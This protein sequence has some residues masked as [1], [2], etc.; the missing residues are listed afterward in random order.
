MHSLIYYADLFV[1]DSLTMFTESALLGTP[2]ISISS[3]GYL[4]GNF[5]E[6]CQKYELGFRFRSVSEALGKIKELLQKSDIKEEWKKKRNRLLAEKRDVTQFQI[7]L[8]ANY[9]KVRK[10]IRKF[11]C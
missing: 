11:S 10:N 7:D 1:G 2:S 3:E 6:I 5:D 8:I 9:N 4:L